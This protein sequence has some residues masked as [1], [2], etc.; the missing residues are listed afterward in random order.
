MTNT[1]SISAS[2]GDISLVGHQIVQAGSL[3]SSTSAT[4][5]G[6]INLKARDIVLI[7]YSIDTDTKDI[8]DKSYFQISRD[9]YVD[10]VLAYDPK[11]NPTEKATGFI[12]GKD[13]G[14]VSFSDGSRTE[15]AIDGSNG[16]TLTASQHFVTSSVAV[17]GKKIVEKSR[18]G[19]TV[20][21]P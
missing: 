2:F 19:W 21:R 3:Y 6:S 15:I 14:T 9:F 13:G 12:Y 11:Q 17:Q 5:N 20:V 16:K 8:A 10:G 18:Q 1:G 4:A 7:D